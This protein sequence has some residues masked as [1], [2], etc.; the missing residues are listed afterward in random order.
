MDPYECVDGSLLFYSQRYDTKEI[1]FLRENLCKGGTFIDIGSNIGYYSLQAS[2]A[3]ENEGQIIAIEADPYNV[4]KILKNQKL[5]D[6]FFYVEQIGVGDKFEDSMFYRNNLG[7]SGS[8]FIQSETFIE[9][10]ITKIEPLNNIL[11]KYKLDKIDIMKIDIEGFEYRVLNKY[12]EETD[13]IKPSFILIEINNGYKSSLE[14]PNL[15]IYNGYEVV[16][17]FT[18]NVIFKL[19]KKKTILYNK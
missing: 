10:E 12:F 2:L 3:M 1:K 5:N 19:I 4:I 14:L 16:R 7:H 18:D 9:G 6:I 17:K 11:K 13:S 15:L 8:T